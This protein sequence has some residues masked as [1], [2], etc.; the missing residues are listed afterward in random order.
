MET[1]ES[2]KLII[3]FDGVQIILSRSMRVYMTKKGTIMIKEVKK[4]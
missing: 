3:T 1:T 4:K 2:G